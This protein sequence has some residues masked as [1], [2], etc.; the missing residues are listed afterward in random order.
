M[1]IIQHIKTMWTKDSRGAPNAT[2]RN[3]VPKALKIEGIPQEGDQIYIHSVVADEKK[4]FSL[5][6]QFYKLPENSNVFH[7]GIIKHYDAIMF[8]EEDG[9]WSFSFQDHMLVIGGPHRNNQ[10]LFNLKVGQ[11]GRFLIN[12]RFAGSMFAHGAISY[13]QNI[14]NIVNCIEYNPDIFIENTPTYILDK[15][16]KL[17]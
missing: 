9:Y 1:I 11:S 5:E 10:T 14:Y 4:S 13:E 16:A 8:Y 15:Q 2:L 7:N 6:Q 3:Q 17:F 12:Y